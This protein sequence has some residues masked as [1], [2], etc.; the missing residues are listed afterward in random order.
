MKRVLF[1]SPFIPPEWIAAHGVEPMR[2]IPDVCKDNLG[3]GEGVCPFAKGFA[4]SAITSDVD[5]VIVTTTCD[6]MR[7]LAEI[8][9]RQT[10]KPVF[11]FHVP[12]TWESVG[13]QQYYCSEMR[14]LGHFLEDLGGAIPSSA[15]LIS[16][17]KKREAE[18]EHVLSIRS[19]GSDQSARSSSNLPLAL[20]G[21]PLLKDH[22]C[23]HRMINS[24]GGFIMLDAMETGERGQPRKYNRRQML[25]DPFEEMCS[26]Y[27]AIPDAFQ[28]PNTPLY[29]YLA[30][31]IPSRGI[32][33]VIFVHYV[34]CDIWHG[35][36][37][38]M[39]EWLDV[40]TLILEAGEEDELV[41]W[42]NRLQAFFEV[43]K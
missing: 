1:A 20:I 22:F 26:A 4:A 5:A 11:T 33:G 12:K 2:I 17:M 23:L 8:I 9:Q 15:D 18:K 32:R 13:A 19:V 28:R 43:L 3:L 41:R 7:R 16:A 14:R 6:Q 24:L 36:A 21:G 42:S 25:D 35:E 38:R 27:F 30:R 40:P 37:Q 29:Q 31:Q 34:W 10:P 39:K